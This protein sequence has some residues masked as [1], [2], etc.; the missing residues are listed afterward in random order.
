MIIL[1]QSVSL[2]ILYPEDR[3]FKTFRRMLISPVSEGS[4]Y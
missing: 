3:D 1:I 2:M 4:I